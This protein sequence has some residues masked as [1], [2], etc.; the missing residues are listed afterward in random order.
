MSERE[1]RV[2]FRQTVI[3]RSEDGPPLGTLIDEEFTIRPQRPPS[4]G[5]SHFF[6]TGASNDGLIALEQDSDRRSMICVFNVKSDVGSGVYLDFEGL[7]GANVH[8][9]REKADRGTPFLISTHR[10]TTDLR[11]ECQT[12]GGSPV[13]ANGNAAYIAILGEKLTDFHKFKQGTSTT[14]ELIV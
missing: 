10:W 9:L 2:R 3:W 4:R 12:H 8:S 5:T 1:V 13:S 6:G 14:E 11:F 7:S